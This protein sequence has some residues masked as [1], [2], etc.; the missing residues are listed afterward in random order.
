MIDTEER[1]NE[2]TAEANELV[3]IIRPLFAGVEPEIVGATLGQLLSVLIAGHHPMM[4]EDALTMVIDM[5]RGLV[6]IEV[7]EM[8]DQGRA[9]PEWRGTKQ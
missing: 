8:I 7:E 6:P 1:A 4:R 9:P 2:A 5:V 3:E